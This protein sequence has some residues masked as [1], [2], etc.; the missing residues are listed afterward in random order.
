MYVCMYVCVAHSDETNAGKGKGEAAT[1]APRGWS[2]P[3]RTD[4]PHGYIY[5]NTNSEGRMT[6]PEAMCPM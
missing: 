4:V 2:W 1:R 3:P 6:N 5:A